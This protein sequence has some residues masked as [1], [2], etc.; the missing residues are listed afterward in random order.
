MTVSI[1]WKYNI[2]VWLPHDGRGKKVGAH[3]TLGLCIGHA[4]RNNVVEPMERRSSQQLSQYKKRFA[5]TGTT[6]PAT[7]IRCISESS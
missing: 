5:V 2:L 1:S 3:L 7:K 6:K 4:Q